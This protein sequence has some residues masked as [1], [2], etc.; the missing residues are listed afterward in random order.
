MHMDIF[1]WTFLRCWQISKLGHVYFYRQTSLIFTLKHTKGIK[2]KISI[3]VVGGTH[4]GRLIPETHTRLEQLPKF[5]ILGSLQGHSPSSL[6]PLGPIAAYWCHF[7]ARLVNSLA[8]LLPSF[9]HQKNV[10]WIVFGC[11]SHLVQRHSPLGGS[12][13][14]CAESVSEMTVFSSH[15]GPKSRTPGIVLLVKHLTLQA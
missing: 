15:C 13:L 2:T 9:L 11:L 4:E 8:I 3:A 7:L 10:W 5:F 6:V 1:I 12:N 14:D